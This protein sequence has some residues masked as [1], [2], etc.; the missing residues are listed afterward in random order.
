MSVPTTHKSTAETLEPDYD[1][2]LSFLVKDQRIA[3]KIAERLGEALKVFYFP[4]TQEMLASTD[5]MESMRIPF[6]SASR[7]VVVLYR[8]PWGKTEW[9][10]L[11]EA[12]IQEGCLKR[13]WNTLVFF[14]L[15]KKSRLPVWFPHA[16]V[17]FVLDDYGID[18]LIGAIKARVQEHGGTIEKSNAISR[19]KRLQREAQFLA[20]KARLF[21]DRALIEQTVLAS[22]RYAVQR[23]VEYV[24]EGAE[25]MEPAV[26]AVAEGRHC[27]MTDGRVS[28]AAGWKQDIFNDAG[29]DE[30]V[31]IREFRGPLA[32]P[33]DGRMYVFPPEVLL[34]ERQFMVEVTAT[35]DLAWKQSGKNELIST[36]DLAH[37]IAMTFFDLLAKANRGEIEMPFA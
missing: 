14:Q 7:V 18:E 16:H 2:A 9:T 37:R 31:F 4:R 36:D 6:V 21:K 35:G 13:G 28:M 29:R 32:I 26:R 3:G 15:D 22:V 23:A 30:Y 10:R 5:G 33:R 8:E 25:N 12:A 27:V 1:V 34:K 11:E 20:E 24:Q 19:A 17:R